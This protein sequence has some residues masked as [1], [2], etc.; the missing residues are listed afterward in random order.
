MRLIARLVILAKKH[1][2]DIP[3]DLQGW[4]A[5]PL[6]IHRL[7][8]NSYDCGVWVLAALSAVLRG[9]HV[10]GLRE[11]DIV[12]MRHYLFT[13]TLSLPPAV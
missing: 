13:L 9:R 5:Q 3:T 1:N 7:Q 2:H 10:T 11:D 8:N 6:N 4:V 12:H